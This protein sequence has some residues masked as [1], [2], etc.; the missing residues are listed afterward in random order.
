[1]HE[2]VVFKRH[3]VLESPRWIIKTQIA[4]PTLRV[5]DLIGLEW[6]LGICLSNEFPGESDAADQ[7]PHFKNH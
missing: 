4:E 6:Y 5:S 2:S 1:M 3:H 7:E